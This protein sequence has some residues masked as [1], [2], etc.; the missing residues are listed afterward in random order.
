MNEELRAELWFAINYE[1][2]FIIFFPRNG[3]SMCPTNYRFLFRF[4]AAA[5]ETG[6]VQNFPQNYLL[7]SP[8]PL[9]DELRFTFPPQ[10][11]GG[12]KFRF[13]RMSNASHFRTAFCDI[14]YSRQ[15]N[16]YLII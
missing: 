1:R 12:L 7:D 11:V 3:F 4:L 15:F 16:E 6:T 2:L 5:T 10:M 13:D 14:E 8:P 9:N